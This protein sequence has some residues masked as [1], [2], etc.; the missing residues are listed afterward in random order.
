MKNGINYT[1]NFTPQKNDYND[2]TLSTTD[3]VY[4]K[5]NGYTN[6]S[7]VYP[8]TT[9]C[10]PNYIK[11][12]IDYTTNFAPQKN[13]CDDKTPNTTNDVYDKSNSCTKTS[14]T[15]TTTVYQV[16]NTPNKTN[17]NVL[18][19]TKNTTYDNLNKSTKNDTYQ[20]NKSVAT[21][22]PP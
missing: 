1:T 15:Y 11:N 9:I 22:S 10:T 12:N 17:Y 21:L 14:Y 7:I 18:Y 19:E 3:D 16:S 13:N 5:S 4:D 8:K 20:K 6:K 2:K